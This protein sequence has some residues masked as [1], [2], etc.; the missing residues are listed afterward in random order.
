MTFPAFI[1]GFI[2]ASIF[3]AL[4]HLWRDGGLG[5]LILYLVLSWVGFAAG[6]ILATGLGIKFFE[7]GPLHMG[8]GILGSIGFL[9]LGHWLSL[10]EIEPKDKA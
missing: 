6:H 2:I 7:V 8:F 1:F 5:R 3:G 4:F 9:L 10:I